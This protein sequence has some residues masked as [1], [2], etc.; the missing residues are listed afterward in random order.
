MQEL[1]IYVRA[2]NRKVSEVM[3]KSKGCHKNQQAGTINN[4]TKAKV[5]MKSIFHKEVLEIVSDVRLETGLNCQDC[6]DEKEDGFFKLDAEL[7]LTSQQDKCTRREHQ[8]SEEQHAL[9]SSS[10]EKYREGFSFKLLEDGLDNIPIMKESEM[11]RII[12]RNEVLPGRED[13]VRPCACL[14]RT[15]GRKRRT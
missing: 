11:L 7:C 8:V 9:M 13:A 3:T 10:L 4:K 6:T 1:A 14:H 15:G 2:C 5:I 12:G